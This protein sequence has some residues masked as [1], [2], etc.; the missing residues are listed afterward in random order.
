MTSHESDIYSWLIHEYGWLVGFFLIGCF[1]TQVLIAPFF[2]L[3]D[4]GSSMSGAGWNIWIV[5]VVIIPVWWIYSAITILPVFA[6]FYILPSRN[7]QRIMA[8]T[9]TIPC[10]WIAIS[11]AWHIFQA[12]TQNDEAYVKLVAQFL[13]FFYTTAAAISTLLLLLALVG[14]IISILGSTVRNMFEKWLEKK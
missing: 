5:F 4:I 2:V 7:W 1:I 9:L 8:I 10:G 6:L 13:S 12:S 14:L 11:I 3:S